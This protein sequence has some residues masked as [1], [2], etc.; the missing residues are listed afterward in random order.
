VGKRG[1]APF[2]VQGQRFKVKGLIEGTGSG[3][4]IQQVLVNRKVREIMASSKSVTYRM[5]EWNVE[6]ME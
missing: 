3:L 2:K 6:I 1:Q 5:E 4:N